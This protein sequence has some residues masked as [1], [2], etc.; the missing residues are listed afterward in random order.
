MQKRPLRISGGDCHRPAA[1][2]A[3][4]DPGE[5]DGEGGYY[6]VEDFPLRFVM[7]G[8]GI[9]LHPANPTMSP[10]IVQETD[11]FHIR[12]ILVGSMRLYKKWKGKSSTS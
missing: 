12:G 5:G 3:V 10:I 4:A 6:E 2:G 9:E 7:K 1:Q 11:E 8:N